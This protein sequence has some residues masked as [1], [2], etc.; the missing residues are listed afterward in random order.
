MSTKRPSES[1]TEI[2]NAESNK[3]VP[4][5]DVCLDIDSDVEDI[6]DNPPDKNY[7]TRR[8]NSDDISDSVN[9]DIP[10]SFNNTD[11]EDV[12]DSD[13][14]L[15]PS[16]AKDLTGDYDE[17]VILIVTKKTRDLFINMF[18][19]LRSQDKSN[20]TGTS[21]DMST[22]TDAIS[23]SD[24]DTLVHATLHHTDPTTDI[25]VHSTECD[26][27]L[28]NK[29]SSNFYSLFNILE[30]K[31]RS[32]PATTL[33]EN[34]DTQ[35]EFDLFRDIRKDLTNF[36][37]AGSKTINMIHKFDCGNIHY[38]LPVKGHSVP[39][40]LDKDYVYSI[41][42][43][44]NKITTNFNADIFNKTLQQCKRT[45]N[46]ASDIQEHYSTKL[47]A[48]AWRAVR[49]SHADFRQYSFASNPTVSQQHERHVHTEAT[50]RDRNTTR[51]ETTNRVTVDTRHRQRDTPTPPREPN[52]I[53]RRRQHDPDRFTEHETSYPETTRREPREYHRS[54]RDNRL[55]DKD[56]PRLQRSSGFHKTDFHLKASRRP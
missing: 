38:M 13:G 48:K 36:L 3:K 28:A 9:E 16:A 11:A 26:T 6:T 40:R 21:C 24:T 43:K 2:D 32:I 27:E 4:K 19:D 42:D 45:I 46:I 5:G 25:S 18:K 44:L 15:E 56:F 12:F 31:S 35:E 55:Y 20:K 34:L 37:V 53:Y 10:V 29:T 30:Y 1:H 50:H 39:N 47:V 23:V 22:Q 54:Y 41:H 33:R 49:R 52:S 7:I 17:P 8:E 14:V 51:Q